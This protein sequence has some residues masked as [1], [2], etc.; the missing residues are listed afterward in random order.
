MKERGY[1]LKYNIIYSKNFTE[2]DFLNLPK[3]TRSRITKVINDRLT[4]DPIK[5]SKLLRSRLKENRRLSKEYNLLIISNENLIYLAIAR[6][7]IK[8]CFP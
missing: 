2:I 6:V 3:I 7:M 5:F 4:T 8:R 1:E